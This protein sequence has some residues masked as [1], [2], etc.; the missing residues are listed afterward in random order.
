MNLFKKAV[1]MVAAASLLS[2]CSFEEIKSDK[3]IITSETVASTTTMQVLEVPE[4]T[5][6]TTVATAPSETLPGED[7][8]V[9]ESPYPATMKTTA[10]VNARKGPSTADEIFKTVVEGT[11]VTV[12]GYADSWYQI[13]LDGETVYIIEDYLEIVE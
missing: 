5:T 1:L 4:I 8:P 11:E 10:N 12:I 3:N 9:E 7:E 2:G 6:T 13:D